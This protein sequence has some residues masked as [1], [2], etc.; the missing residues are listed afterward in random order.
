MFFQAT[1][2]I[3]GKRCQKR[4]IGR[5]KDGKDHWLC[6]VDGLIVGRKA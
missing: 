2:H 5:T 1:C 6:R 3:C 4:W